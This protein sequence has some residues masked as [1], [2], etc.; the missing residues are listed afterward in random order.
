[1]SRVHR[2][3]HT[4]HSSIHPI[5]RTSRDYGLLCGHDVT[6]ITNRISPNPDPDDASRAHSLPA[7]HEFKK[8]Q[9]IN[10]LIEC[11]VSILYTIPTEYSTH[12]GR[13]PDDEKEPCMDIRPYSIPMDYLAYVNYCMYGALYILID[14]GTGCRYCTEYLRFSQSSGHGL[15]IQPGA[16]GWTTYIRTPQPS[17]SDR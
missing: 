2:T 14:S 7:L 5:L 16:G 1:M 17:L 3:P 15:Y 4:T 8:R 12:D 11:E 6:V 10:Q 13:W 9:P